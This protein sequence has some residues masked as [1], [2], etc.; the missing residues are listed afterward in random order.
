MSSAPSADVEEHGLE[1]QAADLLAIIDA[2][3]P[4]LVLDVRN[5]EEH[6]S[7]RI[8]GVRPFESVH[9]PYFEFLENPDVALALI[10]SDTRPIAVVCAK[11]GSSSFVAEVLRDAGRDARSVAGGMVSYGDH[12][13]ARRVS[14]N[15]G[16]LA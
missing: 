11:G 3:R 6:A 4:V 5:E 9:V 13:Q 8:E 12:L 16:V 14:S 7:W 1:L 10:P 15:R 2:G